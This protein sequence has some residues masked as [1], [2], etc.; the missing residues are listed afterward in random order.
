MKKL[1]FLQA[2]RG[3]A[4]L[5]VVIL[6]SRINY[7]INDSSV[8]SNWLFNANA[9]GVDLFFIISGFIMV[10]TTRNSDGSFFYAIQF[11]IKRLARIVPVY[12]VLTFIY[13]IVMKIAYEI[14]GAKFGYTWED[15]IQS[16]MFIPLNLK[17]G[18]APFFGSP[19]L[20]VGWTL[21]YEIYFYLIFGISLLFKKFR[22]LAFSAWIATSLYM[23]PHL[24]GNSIT[25][26]GTE[27]YNFNGYLNI[28]TSPLIWEFVAG[29]GIGL[30]YFS[31][32][33]IPNSVVARSIAW[34]SATF[35][36]WWIVSGVHS[37]M[38]ITRWGFPAAIMVLCFAIAS[39]TYEFRVPKWLLWLGNISFSLYL[40]HPLVTNP[41][42]VILWETPA[43][44]SLRDPSFLPLMVALSLA[45]GTISYYY[46]EKRL[47]NKVRDVILSLVR[48]LFSK[49][50]ASKAKD[51]PPLPF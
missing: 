8:I 21:N 23:L 5:M 11:G 13:Y 38:G 26:A 27:Q 43:R 10:Y 12:L 9:S 31:P 2:F 20:H 48:D 51:T 35:A 16:L 17:D 24:H 18:G 39:K 42:S 6:H 30:L 29:V 15:V 14:V 36:F 1:D 22:W 4:A 45:I 3:I 37:D 46:L 40:V 7:P 28:V 32:L 50:K 49:H 41:S 19:V 33:R 34:I 44:E 47:S 25:L